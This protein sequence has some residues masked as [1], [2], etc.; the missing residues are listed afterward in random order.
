MKEAKRT[1][2]ACCVTMASEIA[3]WEA[4]IAPRLRRLGQSLSSL[5]NDI[6][7]MIFE[8]AYDSETSFE[9][10]RRVAIDLSHICRRFRDLALRMQRLWV[11]LSSGMGMDCLSIFLQR[12]GSMGLHLDFSRGS[13]DFTGAVMPHA[14]RWVSAKVDSWFY[15][16]TIPPLLRLK[17]IEFPVYPYAW[18]ESLPPYASYQWTAPALRTVRSQHIPY[19]FSST[20]TTC[21]IELG[22][23]TNITIPAMDLFLTQ[24]PT[25]KHLTFIDTGNYRESRWNG[26]VTVVPNLESLRLFNFGKCGRGGYGVLEAFDFPNLAELSTSTTPKDDHDSEHVLTCCLPLDM[27]CLNVTS[28]ALKLDLPS[29]SPS[30]WLST[31]SPS[32]S[33]LR[34]SFAGFPKTVHFHFQTNAL[35]D[36]RDDSVTYPPLETIKLTGCHHLSVGWLNGVVAGLKN[37]GRW[38]GFKMLTLINCKPLKLSEV[39]ELVPNDKFTWVDEREYDAR[40]CKESDWPDDWE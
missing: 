22:T 23:W 4:G 17:S 26:T 20:L 6:L 31:K 12:N 3:G 38:D 18:C 35:L 7:A 8:A 33:P 30:P 21:T 32:E 39:A 27:I 28:L 36:K 15:R 14:A 34:L 24:T 11:H 37:Q 5:P 29:P 10:K 25:L 9:E 40:W 19:P 2:E 16:M 1:L 13:R